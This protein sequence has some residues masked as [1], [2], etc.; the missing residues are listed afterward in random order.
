MAQEWGD[1]LFNGVSLQES[2]GL[3]FGTPEDVLFPKWRERKQAIPGV[4]GR[5]DYGS[6]NHEERTY[7]IKCISLRPLSRAEVR[8][9]A[10]LLSRKSTIRNW[11]EPDKYYVGQLMDDQ[12]LKRL[13]ADRDG[14]GRIGLELTFTCEPF[15]YGKTITQ[16]LT[17]GNNPIKYK[18][19]AET[20]C[21]IILKNS[22]ASTIQTVQIK[23][24]Y[25]R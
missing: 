24:V 21:L 7:R 14:N 18:G 20:P 19:T 2:F 4:D 11:D 3:L 10:Y 12:P 5:Y 8:E 1:L 16:P 13:T 23:A 25:R 17:N 15:A 22:S 6:R 9:R